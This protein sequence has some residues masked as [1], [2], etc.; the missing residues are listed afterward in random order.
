MQ[1]TFEMRLYYV[2][3]IHVDDVRVWVNMCA[4]VA[5]S[6]TYHDKQYNAIE[7]NMYCIQMILKESQ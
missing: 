3:A 5:Y 4:S 1:N 6:L 2:A 7:M